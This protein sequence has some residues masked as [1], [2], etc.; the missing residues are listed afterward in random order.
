MQSIVLDKP[1]TFVP[2][3]RGELWPRVLRMV[4]DRY[5]VNSHGVHSVELFG[6]ER[7]KQSVQAGHGIMITPNHSRPS[8]PMVLMH[9]WDVAGRPFYTVASRHLFMESRYQTFMLRRAGVFSIYREGMDREALKCSVQILTEA[10][11][12]LVLFPE[13]LISRTNDRLNHLMDGTVFIARNA[14]KQRAAANPPGKV[15]IHP[16][17]I[18][19]FFEGDVERTLTPVLEDI[20]RRLSWKPQQ[21]LSLVDRV[22]KLGDALLTLKEIEYFGAPQTGDFKKRITALIDQI[23]VPLEQEWLKGKREENVV[24]RV[25]SLRTVILPEMIAGEITEQERAR[26]W[27]Q[28]ADIYLAQQL[29]FYPPEYF[30]PEAT[31]EKLLETV[32]RYEEDLTD[33]VRV[34]APVRAALQVGEAIEVSPSRDRGADTDPVMVRVRADL[35]RMLEELKSRRRPQSSGVKS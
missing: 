13:G 12:P 16:V 7:L 2:P 6:A 34:H 1:Y 31:P 28:L 10:R 27:A 18:R 17:A 26:R 4:L 3:H 24:A 5:L 21:A 35:E 8:D 25:K 14:A 30:L 33:K 29:F 22:V 9:L 32:E 23:L 19:Y 11:R 15:V 20:E